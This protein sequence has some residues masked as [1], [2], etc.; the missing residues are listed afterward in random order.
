MNDEHAIAADLA[1]LFI[2]VTAT[3][4]VYADRSREVA[5]DYAHCAFLP[6]RSLAPLWGKS[7]PGELKADISAHMESMV[8]RK[9]ERFQTSSSG[10][11]VQLGLLVY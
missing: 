9:G 8:R 10:Q 7:C 2:G 3:G 11:T 6:Y 4:I 1:R 5:G